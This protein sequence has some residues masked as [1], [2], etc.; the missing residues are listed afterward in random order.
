MTTPIFCLQKIG[1]SS[2]KSKTRRHM[3]CAYRKKFTL[4]RQR[5]MVA[6]MLQKQKLLWY[7]N[8]LLFNQNNFAFNKIYFHNITFFPD[9]K[10][11]FYSVK[12]NSYAVRSIFIIDIFFHSSKLYFYDINFSLNTFLVSIS[13]LPFVFT[14]VRIL[15]S[16]FKL[17]NSTRMW[18][19][20]LRRILE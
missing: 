14:K 9:T 15:L 20:L 3:K 17:N 4:G 10:I 6:E 12:T 16:V 5:F 2:T 1:L 13:G 19:K 7:E 18:K 11:Y 8:K